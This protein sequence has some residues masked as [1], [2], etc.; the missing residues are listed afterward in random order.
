M[1]MNTLERAV[2]MNGATHV[3]LN[4]MDVLNTVG[5]WKAIDGSKTV[6]FKSSTAMKQFITRHLATCGVKAKGVFFSERKDGI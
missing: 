5:V 2:R 1:N 3:V 6:S 4:K